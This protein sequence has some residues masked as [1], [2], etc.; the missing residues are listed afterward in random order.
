MIK[1]QFAV[2]QQPKADRFT[3]RSGRK[4]TPIRP[5]R[6]AEAAYRADL[7][8]VV[9]RLTG[10][11]QERIVPLLKENRE[12]IEMRAADA[13]PEDEIRRQL[14][15]LR[16][17]NKVD[18]GSA[19]ATANRTAKRV[20]RIVDERLANEIRKSVG[21]NIR[22]F[23]LDDSQ[24]TPALNKAVKENVELITSIPEKY[25]D[26]VE[27]YVVEAVTTGT[28]HET[29]AKGI[30][31]IGQSTFRRAQL[32]ARDQTSKMTGSFNR[33]R[34]SSI[35]IDEY[36][37]STSKDERVRPTHIENEGKRFRW[38]TPPEETGHP[39]EDIQCRCVAIP[40][41]NLDEME[42]AVNAL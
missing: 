8:S 26:R 17:A 18:P 21:I 14:N 35:G 6:I 41:F 19:A 5:S 25:F 22:P 4:L 27:R 11:V 32:I 23:M 15:Q 7:Y 29:L 24:I 28:R 42:A 38:D 16:Q 3:K 1:L 9:K 34:Q 13:L 31:E 30:Y 10:A 40:Y 39:G 12:I 20:R 33:I 2:K 37:W 36:V